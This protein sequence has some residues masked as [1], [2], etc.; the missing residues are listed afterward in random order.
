[1]IAVPSSYIIICIWG[2]FSFT[3]VSS[4]AFALLSVCVILLISRSAYFS[5]NSFLLLLH[6]HKRISHWCVFSPSL[7]SSSPTLHGPVSLLCAC[8]PSLHTQVAI[9][10]DL[11]PNSQLASAQCSSLIIYQLSQHPLPTVD[12][13]GQALCPFFFLQRGG[14]LAARSWVLWC[15]EN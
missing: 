11:I 12:Q 10:A 8:S 14:G 1:M 15:S 2:V 9:I 6:T 5:V 4:T 3:C 7:F 13:W